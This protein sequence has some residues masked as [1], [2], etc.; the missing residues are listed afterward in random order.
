MIKQDIQKAILT[1]LKEK[2]DVALNV[3]R[4]MSSQISYA[5]IEKG[6]ELT[7]EEVQ[8]LLTKEVKK[9]TEAIKMFEQ[10]GRT[11]MVQDEKKQLEI[12]SHYLPQ[13]LPEEEVATII[14]EVIASMA[15]IKNPG[16]VIG[17]VMARVKGRASGDIVAAL[18]RQALAEKK[19]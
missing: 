12:I 2:N 14:K 8:A 13:Q 9:R 4:Y 7:D 19:S 11:A 18:V 6:S 15:E 3:L 10:A 1:N 5:Q 17:Q 16:Q